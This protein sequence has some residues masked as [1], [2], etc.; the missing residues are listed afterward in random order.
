MWGWISNF[1]TMHSLFHH[2][3]IRYAN[4]C[5]ICPLCLC[6]FILVFIYW[7]KSPHT[8]RCGRH[9]VP[10]RDAL[11]FYF[12]LFVSACPSQYFPPSP[13]EPLWA[14][15]RLCTPSYPAWWITKRERCKHCCRTKPPASE[16]CGL[17][18]GQGLLNQA[19]CLWIGWQGCSQC[20]VNKV[21]NNRWI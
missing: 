17:A 21:A 11:F 8:Q 12:V 4:N 16:A 19:S 15:M 7:T 20:L 5:N 14:F 2:Q 3:M 10:A 13:P 9:G 6:I 18:A 1:S